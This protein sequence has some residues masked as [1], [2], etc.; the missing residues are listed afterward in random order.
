MGL[1]RLAMALL[2]ACFVSSACEAAAAVDL[3]KEAQAIRDLDESWLAAFAAKD[4]EALMSYFAP[5]AVLMPAGAPALF[6]QQ[7]IRAYF[8]AWVPNPDVTSTFTPETVEVATSGDL[9]Y[10]RGVF[11]FSMETP[12]GRV[13]GQGK[14]VIVWKKLDG[15]WK[16]VV[17]ISNSDLPEARGSAAEEAPNGGE[18][19]GED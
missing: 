16:A 14:Y 9:A 15:A 4:I 7:A 17:D 6:G 12:D 5:D 10:D 1:R 19:E 3:A 2:T 13:E 18:A 8:E 11:H